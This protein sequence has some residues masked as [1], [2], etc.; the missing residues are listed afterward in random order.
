M[1]IDPLSLILKA[2][3][4]INKNF[5]LISGNEDT[6]MNKIKDLMINKI[7]E[8][9]T[10]SIEKVKDIKSI[11][12]NVGLFERNKLYIIEDISGVDEEFLEANKNSDDFFLFISENSN[13]IK[14]FKNIL[15]KSQDCVVFDCY[16]LSKESKIKII[17]KFFQKNNLVINESVFWALVDK[18]DNKYMFL[19]KE[20]EKVSELE[21]TKLELD[22]LNSIISNNSV[23]IEKLFF[24]LLD[25]NENIVNSF[26]KKIK[27][28][29]DVNHFYYFTKQFCYLIISND[30]K[31]D[32][33]RSVPKYLF[34][35]KNFLIKI[36]NKY[37]KNKRGDLVDLLYKTEKTIRENGGLSMMVALRFF[38][39][40]KKITIS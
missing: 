39:S 16:E 1:K 10:C 38:F 33:E 40:L 5:Y 12:N 2:D 30:N 21:I 28:L 14:V 17:K 22:E 15:A 25:S 20:L 4:E 8:Q 35:E 37:T 19:E 36:F 18:L 34:R 29:T 27:N 3:F 32:F 9:D 7:V 11:K 13:K 31:I 24:Q 26:N 6:L 23:V